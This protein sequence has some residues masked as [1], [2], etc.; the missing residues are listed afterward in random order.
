MRLDELGTVTD[1]S[2][3]LSSLARLNGQPVIAAQIK[4]LTG[5]ADIEVTE[6]VRH[7]VKVFAA[8]HHKVTIAE[9]NN[10][11]L[12]TEQN[13]SAS[14]G[15]LNEGAIIAVI[16]VFLFLMEWLGNMAAAMRPCLS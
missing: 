11:I 6:T 7:A 12:P 10:T 15:M 9:A 16:V 4:Q 2:A 5:Y 13:Y 3:D 8:D 14:M 1:T